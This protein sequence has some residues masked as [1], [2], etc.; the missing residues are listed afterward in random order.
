MNLPNKLTLAETIHIVGSDFTLGKGEIVDVTYN[1]K[2]G[3]FGKMS[4]VYYKPKVLSVNIDVCDYSI[5]WM[6]HV[7]TELKEEA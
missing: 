3:Y 1:I 4:G 5:S 7:F 2:E 6:P